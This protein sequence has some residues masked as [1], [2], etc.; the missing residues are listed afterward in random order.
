MSNDKTFLEKYYLL[1][2][3]FVFLSL[4][5]YFLYNGKYGSRYYSKAVLMPCLMF[6]FMSNT[7]FNVRSSP[8]TYTAR[9]LLYAAFL[10][11]WAGDIFGL[12][13][14]TFFWTAWLYLYSFSYII[15]CIILVSIQ[16]NTTKEETFSFYFKNALPAFFVT[17]LLSLLF[18][19]KFIGLAMEFN[20]LALYAH[21]LVLSMV[22]MFTVNM[23][24][25]KD[26][27]RIYPLFTISLLFLLAANLVYAAD[28][29]HFQRRL[30]IIDVIVAITNGLSQVFFVLGVIKFIRV[31]R[32]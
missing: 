25:S 28:E 19:Y 2:I 4:D 20:D 13:P 10:F 27:K 17:L 30:P 32:E 31:K 6:W 18:L 9:L 23:W 22:A 16:I 5:C 15:Y 11:T 29:I 26:L 14:N 12:L 8:D 1:L 21:T 24:G 7:A 3:Y